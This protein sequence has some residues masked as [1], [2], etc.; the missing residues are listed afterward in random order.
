MNTIQWIYHLSENA[1][2]SQCLFQ[3]TKKSTIFYHMQQ[4][5][6]RPGHPSGNSQ[7]RSD[8][9]IKMK[10][11]VV[12]CHDSITCQTLKSSYQT[13]VTRSRIWDTKL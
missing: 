5:P 12:K 10:I 4:I 7:L 3:H 1:P 6:W 11:R 9:Q 8:G 13:K 2:H